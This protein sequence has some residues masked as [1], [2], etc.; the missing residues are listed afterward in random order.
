M[1]EPFGALDPI[2]REK[3]QDEF[4]SIQ[5]EVRK[6]ILFVSHDID[7]AVKMGDKIAL[8]RDGRIMQYDEP[9]EMLIRPK[10]E[11]VS[12]FIGKDR[13]LKSMSLY[14]VQDLVKAFNLHANVE[15]DKHTK[16]ISMD[17]S[18]R[19]AL[20]IL[21]NQEADQLMI[22]DSNRKAHGALTIDLIEKFLHQEVKGA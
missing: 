10:N 17:T 11:F 13:A 21:L 22:V 20:S 14:T 15:S 7:E 18:L 19:I 9:T 2:I 6:T 12:D 8:L 1:D 4:L 3:V 16:E 5:K